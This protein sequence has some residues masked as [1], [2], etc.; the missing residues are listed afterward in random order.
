MAPLIIFLKSNIT[1]ESLVIAV[2]G[3][4]IVFTALVL[5]F[6][7]FSAVP[8]LI[9]LGKTKRRVRLGKPPVI[10]EGEAI[11]GEA[12]AAIAMALHLYMD[13]IHDKESGVLTIKRISK[14]YSPWSS[15]I[16]AVR[17]Q[18]NRL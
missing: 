3:Y 13:E 8:R 15:K 17:N 16:Y 2:S 10:V 1:L 6:W 12:T 14:T 11:S 5:L 18:F 7:F 9:A 4:L